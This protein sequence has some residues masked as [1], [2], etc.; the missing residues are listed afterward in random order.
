MF[1][2]MCMSR[3]VYTY[4]ASWN[5]IGF[6]IYTVKFNATLMVVIYL[7]SFFFF[8]VKLCKKNNCIHLFYTSWWRWHSFP[9]PSCTTPASGDRAW[10]N[11]L[12]VIW[13]LLRGRNTSEWCWY[14]RILSTEG[15]SR[16]HP[17]QSGVWSCFT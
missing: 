17:G 16:C 13:G 3:C 8:I 12:H 14:L 5:T 15:R 7:K 6:L 1:I 11:C 9:T 2:I 10:T 4:P